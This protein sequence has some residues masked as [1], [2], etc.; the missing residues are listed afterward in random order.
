MWRT[1][2][3]VP[4]KPPTP[5]PRAGA[6]SRDPHGSP[7]IL[8]QAKEGSEWSQEVMTRL[9]AVAATKL[10]S[11]PHYRDQVPRTSENPARGDSET[12]QQLL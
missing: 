12:P 7:A 2:P 6:V 5:A 9:E 4:R 10:A 11:D 3:W 8:T 1:S